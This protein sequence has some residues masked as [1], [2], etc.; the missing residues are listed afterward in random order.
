MEEKLHIGIS[1]KDFKTIVTHAETLKTVISVLYSYP[2][3]AMQMTYGEHGMQCE[4]TLM[5]I[6]GGSVTAAAPA[7]RAVSA[8]PLTRPQS[9]RPSPQETSQR[10]SAEMPPP[11]Q[12]AS[13]SFVRE[14]GSQRPFKPS[15]PPPPASVPHESLFIPADDDDSLWGER[16]YDEEEDELG[17]GGSVEKVAF[18]CQCTCWP[19]LTMAN[20]A[21]MRPAYI[22]A[23]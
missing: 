10:N 13:R 19:T 6:G 16:N 20:R 1:V 17:W 7:T 9:A 14:A 12:P 11:L 3:Q 8:R 15:P 22:E 5:T 4:F 2:K 21:F 23:Q 18:W